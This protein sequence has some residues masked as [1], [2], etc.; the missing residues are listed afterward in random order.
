MPAS[1]QGPSSL[2]GLG[3]RFEQSSETRKGVFTKNEASLAVVSA[4]RATIVSVDESEGDEPMAAVAL[5]LPEK[6]ETELGGVQQQQ[7][8]LIREPACGRRE[9]VT[10]EHPNLQASA[11]GAKG[12][13]RGEPRPNSAQIFRHLRGGNGWVGWGR[14]FEKF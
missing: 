8:A 4:R 5:L 3:G 9:R 10:A 7:G 13:R 14:L 12:R 6:I 1:A 2:R 11:W